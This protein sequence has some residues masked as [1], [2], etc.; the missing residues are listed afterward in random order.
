M[1]A[2][3][4]L[5]PHLWKIPS[6]TKT[7]W[8]SRWCQR[9]AAISRPY[10]TAFPGYAPYSQTKN[11]SIATA[12]IAV[13]NSINLIPQSLSLPTTAKIKTKT[14][15]QTKNCL[16]HV[17]V[18][19]RERLPWTNIHSPKHKSLNASQIPPLAELGPPSL[20]AHSVALIIALSK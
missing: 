5:W 19:G 8:S 20:R 12:R 4:I 15:N 6:A 10:P 13:F 16:F 14:K 7:S 3:T 11:S 18:S 9:S 1:G 2:K 17:Y